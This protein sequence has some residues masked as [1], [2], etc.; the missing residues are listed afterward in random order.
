MRRHFG[1][2]FQSL[3]TAAQ[4]RQPPGEPRDSR[5]RHTVKQ[6]EAGAGDGARDSAIC[7]PRRRRRLRGVFI[8]HFHIKCVWKE[9]SDRRFR[10]ISH[11]SASVQI[12]EP[13]G[14]QRGR[15]KPTNLAAKACH[16][17][18]GASALVPSAASPHPP[19][20]GLAD[21]KLQGSSGSSGLESLGLASSG[22]PGSRTSVARKLE[23]A[24][25]SGSRK[26]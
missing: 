7:S 4:T 10:D 18:S 23:P 19:A 5:H 25:A 22:G 13:A 21:P 11:T 16:P 1:A 15:G 20:P 26:G 12:N 8:S 24:V 3:Q 9:K 2:A 17:R 14:S 6:D